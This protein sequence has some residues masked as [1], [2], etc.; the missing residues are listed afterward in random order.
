MVKLNV[1]TSPRT[2]SRLNILGVPFLFVYDNG[3]M[4]ETLPAIG[5]KQALLT[6][7]APYT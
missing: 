5:D 1:G 4:R 2:A 6:R 7:L 3:K